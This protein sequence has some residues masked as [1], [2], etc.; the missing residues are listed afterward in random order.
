MGGNKF[1][2]EKDAL[3]P[4]RR[5][6]IIPFTMADDHAAAERDKAASEKTSAAYQASLAAA[7]AKA[8]D[9]QLAARNQM[10]ADADVARAKIDAEL[11]A[12][13]ADS[14]KTIAAAKAKALTNIEDVAADIA[15]SIV[16]QLTGAKVT[17][18]AYAAAVAK[19]A[20]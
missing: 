17:K 2:G 20:K 4:G 6:G 12:K 18:V 8:S 13:A 5:E 3:L 14:E 11:S 9:A 15:S 10:N 7:R 16:Y 1:P 19:A